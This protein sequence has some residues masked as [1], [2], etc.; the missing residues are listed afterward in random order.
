LALRIETRI[1]SW[2]QWYAASQGGLE[3]NYGDSKY[4]ITV[5]GLRDRIT[6]TVLNPLLNADL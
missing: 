1:A 3:R 6:V 2:K 5:T 4:R